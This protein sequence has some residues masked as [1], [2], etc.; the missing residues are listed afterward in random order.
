M[1][2][3]SKTV[4]PKVWS[5]KELL[6][7]INRGIVGKLH[8]NRKKYWTN[9]PVNSKT[10][11]VRDFIKFLYANKNTI[12]TITFGHVEDDKHKYKNVDGNNRINGIADYMK[13]PFKFFDEYLDELFS[14]LDNRPKKDHNDDNEI[15]E[16]KN[17]FRKTSY[18]DFI[19]INR[20]NKFLP[21]HLYRAI[22]KYIVTHTSFDNEIQNIRERLLINDEGFDTQVKVLINVFEGYSIEELNGVFVDVNQFLSCMELID[23]LCSKLNG[24]T[25]FEINNTCIKDRIQLHIKNYYNE[26]KEGE[27]LDCYTYSIENDPINAFNFMIGFQNY[28][29]EKNSN[30]IKKIEFID[31][32]DKNSK[33]KDGLTLF[34]KLYNV[35]FGGYDNESF[36]TSDNVNNFIE[37]IE[38]SCKILN[39]C[40]SYI[41]TDNIKK[42]KKETPLFSNDCNNKLITKLNTNVL[43]MLFSI[44][45]GCIKQ[46]QDDKIIILKIR[47]FILF[48]LFVSDIKEPEEKAKWQVID[49]LNYK[50]GGKYTES[51]SKNYLK[52]PPEDYNMD[53][54]VQLL[55][56][57]NKENYFPHKRNGE[58][59]KG[60]GPGKWI[61]KK[62]R[63]LKF[64]EKTLIFFYYKKHVSQQYLNDD[65]SIEHIYPHS[66]TW[67]GELDKDRLG[68]LFPIIHRINC[69][70][71]SKHISHYKEKFPEF[72]SF[73]NSMSKLIPS[74]DTYNSIINH[75]KNS[76][77]QYSKPFI[78]DIELFNN[79]CDENENKYIEN[80]ISI[81]Y[82]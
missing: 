50:A 56:Y 58:T 16:I 20:L 34:F 67:V 81:L 25:C 62:R 78:K 82:N 60:T 18:N 52:N 49:K 24:I 3:R 45:I 42:D 29:S 22:A 48:H 23:F 1:D 30:F 80:M 2:S 12:A 53:K 9:K 73:L 65:F 71:Q 21:D 57:L 4:E 46:E 70:R 41:F 61:E 17:I 35:V 32:S 47:R 63:L 43:C 27:V 13:T 51:T 59:D 26:K 5:I 6:E 75:E 76:Q 37:Y 7:K 8:T 64:F 28:M 72:E 44:I 77:N 69:S 31:N 55:K 40:V 79:V 36:Y 66:S 38:K 14:I 39:E 54:F 15:E 19:R 68:N 10:P 11:N 74:F 33:G